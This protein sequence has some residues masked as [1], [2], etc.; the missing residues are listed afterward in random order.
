MKINKAKVIKLHI[1]DIMESHR[2]DPITVILEDIGPRQGKI[3]IECYGQSWSAYWGGMGD[4]T[5]SEFFCSC[6]NG[7]LIG[8]L[9]PSLRPTVD[10]YDNL[11]KWLKS[12]IISSRRNHEMSAGDAKDTWDDVELLCVNDESFLHSSDGARL[13]EHIIGDEWWYT[14]PQTE[15]PKYEYLSRIVSTVKEALSK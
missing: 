2:L 1:T 12:G 11:D 8:N 13:A 9:A 7:Y 3:I 4:N 10:D 5:I 15:N 14:I 6:D